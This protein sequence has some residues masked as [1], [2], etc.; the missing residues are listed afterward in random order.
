MKP[1]AC[2]GHRCDI[3][4]RGL[5]V[6]GSTAD[7]VDDLGGAKRFRVRVHVRGDDRRVSALVAAAES[8]EVVHVIGF[9]PR[10]ARIFSFS[11]EHERALCTR[12]EITLDVL[13]RGAEKS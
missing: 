1:D 5:R 11:C 8:G 10:P 4:V 3:E 6:R 7:P 12:F 13:A 2:L 9:G